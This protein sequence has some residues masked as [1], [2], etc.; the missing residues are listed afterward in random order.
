[1]GRQG[2]APPDNVLLACRECLGSNQS[3]LGYMDDAAGIPINAL[4][5]LCKHNAVVRPPKETASIPNLPSKSRKFSRGL[6]RRIYL[7]IS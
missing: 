7:D 1:M 2:G 3:L 5:G 6:Q 4:A